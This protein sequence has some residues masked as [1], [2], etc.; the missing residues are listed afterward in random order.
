MPHSLHVLRGISPIPTCIQIPQI[1]FGLRASVN[2]G[3]SAGNFAG[4]K[5]LSPPRAFMIE[6]NSVRAEQPVRFSIVHDHPVTVYLGCTIWAARMKW[7]VFVLR[8]RS[9]SKHLRRARLI[10]TAF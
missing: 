1:E 2:S 4:D 9:R 8:S 10:K 7:C 5:R 3:Y 6:E